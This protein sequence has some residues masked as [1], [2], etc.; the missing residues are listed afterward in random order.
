MRNLCLALVPLLVLPLV[1]Q[2]N[3]I[4]GT[5]VAVYEVGGPSV[6]GR[7]GPAYPNGT[8]GV[9]IG[10]SMC[11]NGSLNVP[12][13]GNSGG[14]M[15]ETYPKIAFLLA[16]E[17][18]GRMV[19]ISGKS[20][21]KHS[22]VAF[23]FSGTNPC[24]PC[25]SGPSNT[26]HVGCYDVYSAGFNGSQSN[27][28]PT[29]E[30]N[31]WLGSW[32][33]VGSYFDIGDPGQAGYP[34]LADGVQ[35]LS[36]SG[37]DTVKNRMAVP[38]QELIEPGTFYGQNHVVI[39]GEPVANRANNVVSRPVSF[40]WSGS[41]WSIA[42]QG[43]S[44]QGSVLQRWSGATVDLGGNGADD[45]R[46]EVAV[47]VTGPVRGMW[48][49][50]YAVHNFDNHR[51]GA[52]LRIPLCQTARLANIGFRDID[53]DSLNDW[54]TVR[55]AN[56]LEIQAGAGNPLD[57]NTLY[58]FWFDS[59]AAP[60]TGVVEIDEARPGPG[61]LTVVVP[62]RVPGLLGTE[63][64]GAGCGSPA[65]LAYAN[66]SPTSPNP[67]YAI[68]FELTP[69]GV[70][71]A[72]FGL[73]ADNLSLGNGCTQYLDGNQLVGIVALSADASGKAIQ[74]VP[75]QA[76]MSPVDWYCQGFEVVGSGGPV[77]G[78]LVPSNGLRIRVAGTG[79]P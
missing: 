12:W 29:S 20:N 16:R 50:E 19:Q 5:D 79:C 15:I 40:S 61:A 68:E 64:L 59:D 43:A 69:F 45:G 7:I 21:L 74:T 57:W 51:G 71:V 11:N 31:P 23:N 72:A 65:P 28:G 46:F 52:S 73:A 77:L 1:G 36:I 41:S 58:N 30:I 54:T 24:G 25:Q 39:L 38:E 62:A 10:H 53:G 34:A 26:F 49:Y 37:F 22:R 76:G 66:G 42:L 32:N 6:Y 70:I 9:V 3:A 47:K 13:I 78:F 2:S 4:P 14:V 63:Y 60:T 44:A 48:H 56:T 17:S 18:G 27:L 35:S 33:P 55:T 8:A 75:L 67:G